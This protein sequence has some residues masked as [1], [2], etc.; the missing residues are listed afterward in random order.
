[1]ARRFLAIQR[2]STSS[3]VC[4]QK[5]TMSVRLNSSFAR[6]KP[7]PGQV[8]VRPSAR[9]E[10]S[11]SSRHARSRRAGT[12]RAC[13]RAPPAAAQGVL[14]LLVVNLDEHLSRVARSPRTSARNPADLRHALAEEMVAAL[15][16]PADPI[17]TCTWLGGS[18]RLLAWAAS[19]SS[20]LWW[21]GRG[22][23]RRTD[24]AHRVG[25]REPD[26][27]PSELE[28]LASVA[29]PASRK[30]SPTGLKAAT[31]NSRAPGESDRS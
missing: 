31:V 6:W 12:A 22:P 16:G 5:S 7:S 1:M 14:L 18:S 15:D 17:S 9:L 4:C 11:M 8:G 29:H 3:S 27:E 28:S 19:A 10:L 20:T 30:G 23:P 25:G 24:T 21:P 26:A 2:P 13:G